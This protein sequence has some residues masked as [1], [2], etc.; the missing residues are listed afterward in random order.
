MLLRTLIASSVAMVGLYAAPASAAL[1]IGNCG[2]SGPNGV[3][4]AA[5]TG[6]GTFD[7][8]STAGGQ[9]GA[10]QIGG[11]SQNATNGSELV[12]DTFFATA[13][14]DISFWFNYITSDGSGFADYGF[15]QLINATSG[16]VAANLFTARTKPSGTIA[17]G[18]ELPPLEATLSP[19]SVPIIPGA[20]VFSGLG[21]S[22]G[23]CYNSGCGYTGWIESNY[24]VTAAGS[25]QLR[26]GVANWNDT[27]YDSALAFSGLILDGSTIGDGS[28]PQSPLL[29]TGEIGPNGSFEFTFTPT[30]NVPVFIDPTYAEGYVYELIA[31]DNAITK[32]L[33]PELSFDTDGYDV[34]TLDGMLL[35]QGVMEYD[36][37]PGGVQG[38]KLLDI[39]YTASE[40]VDPTDP[41]GFVT[42]L[43][44]LNGNGVTMTQTPL[45]IE[46]AGV[47][48][49]G[50]WA[51]MIVGFGAVGASMRRGT[52]RVRYA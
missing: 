22:S 21:A 6:N 13:G 25:Y 51:M 15:A 48:E 41:T 33:F 44:Y 31:G 18:L 46:V 43:I 20:P 5:P 39:D 52:T 40:G 1:C 26:F 8:I 10:A 35:A 17:P 30:P 2:T 11:Y 36:F 38:F 4:T 29:P 19:A 24:E 32:A 23:S 47:P 42:G 34:Y 45:T 37:G 50:A 49:P 27:I 9:S 7:W 12:S 14:Q 3:V 16:A 28:T